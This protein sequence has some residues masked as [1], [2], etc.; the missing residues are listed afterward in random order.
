MR[1]VVLNINHVVTQLQD[2]VNELNHDVRSG[3]EQSLPLFLGY[4]ERLRL[5]ADTAIGATQVIERQ[6]ALLDER[7][8]ATATG[9]DDARRIRRTLSVSTLLVDA[10]PLDHPTARQR[11]IGRYVTGL[12]TGLRDIDA[13]VVALYGT[14]A[15]AD[16]LAATVPGIAAER[17]G[18]QT[19]RRHLSDRTWYLATQLMLHPIPLDPIPRCVTDAR[20]PVAAVMYDVIPYRY[21]DLYFRDPNARRQASLRAPLARTVDALLAISDFAASTAAQELDYPLER[22]RT[23]G[24]GAEPKFAPPVEDPRQRCRRVLPVEVEG[25]VVAV[26]G[27][28]ERKN[29]EGLLRAWAHVDRG[30]GGTSHLVIAAAHTP[31]VAARWHRWAAEAGVSD[32]VV[33]TG[34]VDDDELVA[35]F[36]GAQLAVMPSLEEGFG[37]PVLEAAACG[38]PAISSNVSSLPEVLD[39]PTSCFDPHDPPAIAAA[40]MQAL[41]DDAHRATLLAAGRRATERWT[42]PN[43][44]QS[45]IGAL[46]RTRSSMAPTGAA[47]SAADRRCRPPV[48]RNGDVGWRCPPQCRGP[49]RVAVGRRRRRR[50]G[51][52]LRSTRAD[53]SH[54]RPVA[55]AGRR[56][57]RAP[58]GRRRHRRR[59]RCCAGPSRHVRTGA[60]HAVPSLDPRRRIGRRSFR[61]QPPGPRDR[62]DG[63]RR[64]DRSG[65]TGASRAADR[66]CPIL[67]IPPTAS[68]DDAATALAAWLDDAPDLDPSTIRRAE[69]DRPTG[70]EPSPITSPDP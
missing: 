50:T 69:P 27:G 44:A 55:G 68:D 15:E 8:A 6:L 37:L 36:Q 58:L 54:T 22:I 24:A 57:V 63:D 23:I 25:Y 52:D 66:P 48:R 49:R 1:E 61:C 31:E 65:P 14:D 10:R 20:L 67:V 7:L 11:G 28:D 17:W 38:V 40:I 46:D 3:A 43:V 62:S 2:T 16:V 34:G 53:P 64:V 9:A 26:A 59:A 33:F 35:L 4:S 51:G 29:T 18:P 19:V 30:I 13:P 42:W 5:D 39:E 70:P 45:T 56:P 12:L 60:D 47:T 21:P 32:R 41:T